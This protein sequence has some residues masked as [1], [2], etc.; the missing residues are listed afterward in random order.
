[1]PL[2][3][4]FAQTITYGKN[5]GVAFN[6]AAHFILLMFGMSTFWKGAEVRVADVFHVFMYAYRRGVVAVDGHLLQQYEESF[7]IG[8]GIFFVGCG[9]AQ[10][11]VQ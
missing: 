10:C 1:M 6:R 7:L 8:C 2:S 5:G 4:E 9:S 11:L 3:R